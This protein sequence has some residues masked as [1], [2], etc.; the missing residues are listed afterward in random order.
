VGVEAL[1]L[2]RNWH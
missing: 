2:I 1:F